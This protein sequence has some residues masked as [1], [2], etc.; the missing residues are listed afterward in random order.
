MKMKIIYR[1]QKK[2]A[3]ICFEMLKEITQKTANLARSEIVQ[4]QK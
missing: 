4:L 2:I 1:K 3:S